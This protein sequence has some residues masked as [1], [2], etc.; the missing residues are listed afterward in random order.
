MVDYNQADLNMS[1]VVS[2]ADYSMVTN[3]LLRVSNVPNFPPK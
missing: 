3:N 2:A 1:A